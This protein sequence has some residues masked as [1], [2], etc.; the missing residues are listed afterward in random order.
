MPEPIERDDLF[1]AFA[2]TL[3]LERGEPVDAIPDVD[4]LLTWLRQNALLSER[5]RAAEV[6]RLHRDAAEAE[7]RLAR[8]RR[9]RDLIAAIADRTS[10]GHAADDDPDPRAQP[11]PSPRRPLPPATSRQRSDAVHVRPD[12]G[13]ARPGARDDRRRRRPDS[14]PRSAR[15]A[16]GHAPTRGAGTCSST[17]RPAGA[18]AGAT[19]ERAATRPRSR[20]IVQR[21]GAKAGPHGAR[22]YQDPQEPRGV[23]RRG[24]PALL[25]RARMAPPRTSP[26]ASAQRR[27]EADDR[28]IHGRRSQ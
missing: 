6:G 17:A 9:L 20:A 15:V 4:A 12:R 7:R 8:F 24:F 3:E 11:H 5:G 19:C 18:G 10:D 22:R 25:H 21:R 1:V 27:I 26:R 13:P 23:P 16:C 2:N 14:W 28:S